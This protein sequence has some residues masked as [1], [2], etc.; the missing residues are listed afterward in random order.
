M[1]LDLV[2]PFDKAG[3][4]A[5]ELLERAA[6]AS[7]IAILDSRF[8]EAHKADQIRRHPASWIHRHSVAVQVCQPILLLVGVMGFGLLGA[9]GV[10]VP[11]I[12]CLILAFPLAILPLLFPVRGPA[13]WE[14]IWD[15]D[16]KRVHPELR[17]VARRLKA[18]FPQACLV[19]GELYQ[20][21]TRLDPYLV[22]EYRGARIV[23]GIWDDERLILRA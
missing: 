22:A 16:L 14:E 19:L 13:R 2:T 12:A 15:P 4:S 6:S 8:L 21:R 23:L 17:E 20:E 11:A 5:Q 1:P 7:G 3:S 10:M 18:N 9:E